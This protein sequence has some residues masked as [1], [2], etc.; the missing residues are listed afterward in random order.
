MASGHCNQLVRLP[1]SR[2]HETSRVVLEH[3]A[4]QQPKAV[5]PR[6]SRSQPGMIHHSRKVGAGLTTLL[7]TTS[8]KVNC[9]ESAR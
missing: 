1:L 6:E 8:L 7:H 9:C 3:T 5:L 4:A 2:A